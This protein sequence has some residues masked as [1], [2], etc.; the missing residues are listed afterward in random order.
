M[1]GFIKLLFTAFAQSITS[2]LYILMI[3]MVYLQIKNR[4]QLEETWLGFLRD[5]VQNRLMSGMLYGMIAGLAASALI[6]AAGIPIDFNTILIIWPLALILTLLNIRYLCFAYA[7]GLLSLVSLIFKWPDIN[8]SAVIAF[9]GILHLTESMLILLDGH[10]DAL[11]VVMEHQR[12]KPIGA[13]VMSKL[14]PV[15]L[16]ILTTPGGILP[17]AAG[18]G[19]PMP[20][21]WPVFSLQ[22]QGGLILFPIAVILEYSGLAVTDVPK[23]RTRLA[24]TLLGAYSL[25]MIGVAALSV[26]N[27]WLQL[28]GAAL[29]P[30]L[31]ELISYW[32]KRGQLT[33]KPVFGAPWRGL[34]VLDVLPDKT[35]SRMGLMPGDIILN[36]NGKGVNSQ[37]MLQEILS[38]SPSYLWMDLKRRGRMISVEV[39]N[40]NRNKD[41]LGI[42]IVP[43]KA[44]RLFL[45]DE[46]YGLAYTMWK[47]LSRRRQL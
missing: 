23:M 40:F 2:F 32:T 19:I 34:R 18:R 45:A 20:A 11:P 10:R 15:P 31:H 16:I 25:L 17:A 5:T 6:V 41:E 7:G 24:G 9:I 27:W 12:F 47:W 30:L 35:G 28:T 44:S 1:S 13:F 38:S 3:M 26:N 4:T 46:Q 14:W 21:W 8:V 39:R 37:E 33:G 36:V 42:V 29:M 22:N 43:R